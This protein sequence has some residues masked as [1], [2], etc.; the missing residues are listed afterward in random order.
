[1]GGGAIHASG[2]R[3]AR[4]NWP[5]IAAPALVVLQPRRGDR[6]APRGVHQVRVKPVILQ[7][8]HQPAGAVAGLERGRGARRQAADHLQDRLRPMGHVP[9]RQDLTALIDHRHLG[10]LAVHID[11]DVNR[12]CRPPFRARMSPGA[13]RYRAEQERGSG[14]TPGPHSVSSGTAKQ[15]TADGQEPPRSVTRALAPT[16]AAY[17]VS[18]RLLARLRA[19]P[20]RGD[21]F[22]VAGL[23]SSRRFGRRRTGP[24]RRRTGCR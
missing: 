14:L 16:G 18:P 10:A 12:H 19:P 7:Q 22:G 2:S 8:F 5:R 20:R 21:G 11:S 13:S 3:S 6:L 4:S 24:G 23:L 1:M 9:V 15:A 17:R